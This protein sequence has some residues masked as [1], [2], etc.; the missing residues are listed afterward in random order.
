M[1]VLVTG[2]AGFIGSH[3]CRLLAGDGHEVISL[4]NYFTGTPENHVPGVEYRRGHTR[5]I[6][7]H[8]PETPDIVFHLGEYARVEKSFEDPFELLWDLNTAGT[9]SVLEYCAQKGAKLVY[10]GSSTKFATDGEGKHM[11]PYAWTKATNTELV[12]NFGTW[13]GLRYAIAYFYN[14]YGA[15]EIAAG[16]YATVV[17]VFKEEYRRGLPL[18]VVSPGTQTRRFTHV[19]DIVE[20]IRLIG[21]RGEGDGYHISNEGPY[22]ILDLARLFESEIIMMPERKGNRTGSAV[23]TSKTK[24][25]GWEPNVS[26]EDHIREFRAACSKESAVEKRILVF[27]TTFYPVEGPAEKAM[28]DL[29]REMKDVRFDVITTVFDKNATQTPMLPNVTVHR[30]GRGHWTDKYRLIFDGL[31]KAKELSASHRYLFAWG[32]MASYASIAAARFRNKNDLPLL[33]TLADQRLN[34]LPITSRWAVRSILRRADQIS[35]SFAQQDRGI[36]RI[37]PKI[38]LTTSNRKGDAFANQV[39]FLYNM[40]LKKTVGRAERAPEDA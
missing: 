9:F 18:T 34:R 24:A 26:L 13:F 31:T 22:S 7:A 17:G 35:T 4:D 36:S 37:D 16:P 15:G 30:V 2:G 1:N 33:I 5:D 20:G 10:A 39:R 8:V 12:R 29:M 3:L 32:I 6:A 14:V 28:A 21:E 38:G 27:S 11:S 40:L 25:L 19:S 23:D